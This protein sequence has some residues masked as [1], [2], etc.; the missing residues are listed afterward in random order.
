MSFIQ[1]CY[2]CVLHIRRHTWFYNL[3]FSFNSKFRPLF[4]WGTEGRGSGLLTAA[5]DRNINLFR[6]FPGRE[7]LGC[8][9]FL[10][11][12]ENAVASLPARVWLCTRETALPRNVPQRDFLGLASLICKMRRLDRKVIRCDPTSMLWGQ[13][14][15]P[16]FLHTNS[17]PNLVLAKT[18]PKLSS[19]I[20]IFCSYVTHLV[21]PN[22]VSLWTLFLP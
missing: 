22:P 7:H 21:T 8:F 3:F 20:L 1:L 14:K 5:Q 16:L 17:I 10:A 6:H 15:K 11:F 2:V 13:C 4:I 18:F 12:V 19:F 9:Q